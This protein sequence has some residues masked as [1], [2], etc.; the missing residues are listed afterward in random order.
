MSGSTS[1]AALP[2]GLLVAYYGDDFTGSTDAMEAM[3]AAGVPTVLC[4]EPPTPAL[5][6]RFPEAR[7][8]GLAGSSRG[9][10]PAWMDAELPRAF[11]SLAELAAPILHYKVCSTFDSAPDVGSIGRAIDLGVPL[12]RGRW[13]P[14]VRPIR[15]RSTSPTLVACRAS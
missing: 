10:S 8:V 2:D 14:M 13:A 6:A 11:A 4:L 15:A 9:R 3:T 5:L 1:S 12:M 7:C